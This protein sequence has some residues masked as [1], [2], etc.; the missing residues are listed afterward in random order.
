MRT[1]R[2]PTRPWSVALALTTA[3][4]LGSGGLALAT[5]V[6]AAAAGTAFPAHFAAPYLQI[7]PSD[8]SDMAA[9]MA[10][11]GLKYYTLAFLTPQSGCTPEWED[12]GESLGAFTS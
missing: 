10:A 3:A 4:V 6:P 12:G 7:D 1:P 8:A 11:T 9:D 5:A 2:I